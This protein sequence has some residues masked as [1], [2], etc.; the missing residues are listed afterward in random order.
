MYKW[1]IY[2]TYLSVK[3]RAIGIE[4]KKSPRLDSLWRILPRPLS[5]DDL[6][7]VTHAVARIEPCLKW[8]VNPICFDGF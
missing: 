5:F 7:F 4:V 8:P 6:D 2:C 3:D 1:I